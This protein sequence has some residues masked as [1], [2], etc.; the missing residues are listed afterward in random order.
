MGDH[1]LL[2]LRNNIGGFEPHLLAI[3]VFYLVEL[4]AVVITGADTQESR[5]LSFHRKP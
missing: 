5:L 2:V 3:E 1:S 4:R